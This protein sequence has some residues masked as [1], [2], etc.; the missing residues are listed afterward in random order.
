MALGIKPQG[1]TS[2][3]G[4]SLKLLEKQTHTRKPMMNTAVEL[5]EAWRGDIRECVHTGHAVVVDSTGQVVDSWGNAS[6]VTYPRSSAKMVQA[7]PLVE[8]GAAD[9]RGLTVRQL[10]LSCA[11]HQGAEIHRAAVTGWLADLGLSGDN[12]IC[13][14]QEPNDRPERDSLIRAGH[15]PTRCHNNCSGKHSGFLTYCTHTGTGLDYTDPAHA[16]QVSV[17]AA[18]EELAEET[19]PGYGIDGCSAPNYAVSLTGFARA[20]AKFANA[21]KG[22]SARD[23]A[24]VRLREAM[25]THP[26]MVHNNGA[27]DTELMRVAAGKA[28]LKGGA[29]GYY[30]AILPELGFGIALKLDSGSDTAKVVAIANILRRLGVLTKDEAAPWARPEIRNFGGLLAGEW[31]PAAAL[32]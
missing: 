29:D 32:S 27:A 25:M 5:V 23:T 21:G 13:G 19:S 17:R 22:G 3:R 31:R 8:S 12:L 6:L 18:L 7:L 14:P 24:M 30:G 2:L 26:E 10:A 1:L 16:L 28:A 4:N 11:S 9:A 15:A 20:M